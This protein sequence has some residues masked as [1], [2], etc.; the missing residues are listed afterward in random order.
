MSKLLIDSPPLQ[1]LPQL[2]VLIGLNQAIVLQ[3]LHYWLNNSKVGKTDD[4]GVKWVRNSVPEWRQDNFPFWSEKTIKR[5]FDDLVEHNLL[6]RT[7]TLNKF[8]QDR[9]RWY[10]INYKQLENIM[11]TGQVVTSKGTSCHPPK[12]QVVTYVTRDYNRDY[13]RE[14]ANP[15]KKRLPPRTRRS[16]SRLRHH[17]RTD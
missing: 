3:Q 9:T 5:I 2:A 10:T 16:I 14:S 7:D 1:V 12:G 8:K 13:N 11:A 17:R 4:N 6:Y 15:Q